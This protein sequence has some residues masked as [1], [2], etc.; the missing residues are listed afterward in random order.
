[1]AMLILLHS[2][3]QDICNEAAD[4]TLKR[5]RKPLQL[6]PER[7]NHP[8]VSW[9][10]RRASTAAVQD[11]ECDEANIT[12]YDRIHALPRE[13]IHRCLAMKSKMYV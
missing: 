12:H 10:M 9:K 13:S 11:T 8:F 3:L 5:S 6:V 2:T 1:M 7:L 4:S